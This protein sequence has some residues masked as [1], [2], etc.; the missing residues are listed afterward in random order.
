MLSRG[1]VSGSRQEIGEHQ[2]VS[3]K[4]Q[5]QGL[6]QSAL[7]PLKAES[8]CHAPSLGGPW[9]HL[10]TFSHWQIKTL[11]INVSTC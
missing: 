7:L 8:H 4:N 6:F 5:A 9:V 11:S 1:G 2:T 10:V 3:L